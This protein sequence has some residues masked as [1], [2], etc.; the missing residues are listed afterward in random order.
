MKIQSWVAKNAVPLLATLAVLA[1]I[2]LIHYALGP[3]ANSYPFLYFR[4]LLAVVGM[5][6][7]FVQYR[8]TKN[9][10]HLVYAGLRLLLLGNCI[11]DDMKRSDAVPSPYPQ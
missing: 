7:Y 5:T 11:N 10:K 6:A 1:L 9:R 8:K 2:G 4:A 3:V